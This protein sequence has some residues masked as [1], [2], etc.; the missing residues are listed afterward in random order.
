[1]TEEE[2]EFLTDTDTL[3][4]RVRDYFDEIDE[5]LV[6]GGNKEQAWDNGWKAG[7]TEG[8]LSLIHI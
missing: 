7:R 3:L 8:L 5:W 2:L 1:M 6:L 4:N